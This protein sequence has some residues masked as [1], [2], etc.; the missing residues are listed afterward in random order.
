M[1]LKI[2]RIY[3]K[4][5]EI[6]DTKDTVK[7]ASY[8]DLHL[9]I[10]GK[11]KLSTE[12]YDKRN[13]FSF[14]IV[15]FSFFCGN[16]PSASRCGVFIP[17]LIRCTGACRKYADFVSR[18]TSYRLLEQGYVASRLK[19]SLQKI[20]GR[21]HELVDRYDVSLISARILVSLITLE[22][23]VNQVGQ[24]K[25]KKKKRKKKLFFIFCI[26]I[27]NFAFII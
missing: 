13:D 10:D 18:Q 24:N 27:M 11:G 9:E 3:P 20:Y 8:L 6:K 4:E 19:S 7:S 2:L 26:S 23:I 15:N 5:L 25:K 16:I 12:L 14:R 1:K 17:Q 22:H 21:H